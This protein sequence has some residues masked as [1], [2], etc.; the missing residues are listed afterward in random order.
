MQAKDSP[1][2]T[3]LEQQAAFFHTFG[4]LKVPGLFAAEIDLIIDGFEEMFRSFPS[5]QVDPTFSLHRPISDDMETA[6]RVIDEEFIERSPKLA[7]L[8]DDPRITDLVR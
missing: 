4:A 5:K 6:R 2:T 3:S 8:R 1:P 7:W